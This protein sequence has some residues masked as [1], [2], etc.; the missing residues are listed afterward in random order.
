VTGIQLLGLAGLGAFHGLNPGMGWLFAVAIGLQERS[1]AALLRALPPIAAGHAGSV[2][3][4]ATLVTAFQSVLATR[5][6]AIGGGLVLVGFG[7]WRALST[8][9]LRWAGMR[10]SAAQL[11][12]WSFLMSSVHGAGL[13]L[14][15]FL[16]N[17]G[18]A[19]H[20]PHG[21]AAGGDPLWN[22][23]AAVG[24]H[25]VAMVAVAGAVAIVV[26]EVIGLRIL[27]SAW[28]NLDRIWAFALIGAGVAT[29]ALA[30]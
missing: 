29:T 6:V 11:A 27:R 25:T 3:I 22:G 30:M 20:G 4:V 10:L 2:L 19:M 12:A 14:L 7:L 23:L 8:R 18:P 13:M 5:L 26:Y 9:H 21:T 24:V 16:V 1:R 17:G 15:P 28:I